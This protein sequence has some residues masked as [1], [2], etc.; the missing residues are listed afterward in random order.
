MT[1]AIT[2]KGR[3]ILKDREPKIVENRKNS[4]FIKGLHCSQELR[5]FWDELAKFRIGEL[6]KFSKKNDSVPFESVEKIEKYCAKK[7]CSL[8]T[9]FNHTKKRPMNVIFGRLF[10]NKVLEMYEF[11]VMN[12]KRAP[13]LPNGDLQQGALPALVFQGERWDTEFDELRNVLIDF[14]VGD[15]KGTV[16]IEQVTHS[17]VFTISDGETPLIHVRH[18]AISDRK[19]DVKL[20]LIAPS[21]DLSPRRKMLP[22]DQDMKIALTKPAVNKKVKNVTTDELG[23]KVGRV[24]VPKQ[25]TSEIQ[26]H[27]FRGLRKIKNPNAET[28]ND[29]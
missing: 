28:N 4:L 7:Q 25:H 24:F 27:K 8:F 21:F 2:H 14:F 13:E 6:E 29:N 1:T 19:D 9:F 23:R 3:K 22:D 16:G 5:N 18:Y 12:F 17:L 15:L 11:G 26:P 10:N 20:T